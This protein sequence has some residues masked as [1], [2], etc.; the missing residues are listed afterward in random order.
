MRSGRL[1]AML[2]LMWGIACADPTGPGTDGVL[3]FR[4]RVD[5]SLWTPDNGAN[6]DAYLTPDG[7][8]LA[9][10]IRR[11]TLFRAIDGMAVIVRHVQGPGRYP[12]T[13][14][15]DRDHGLYGAFD[16]VNLTDTTFLSAPNSGEVEITQIDTAARRIAGRFSF[17]AQQVDETRRVR[18]SAGVFR[19]VYQTTLP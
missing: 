7:Y 11:D 18:I 17:E 13:S 12:L 8:F 16:P 15:F 5:E 2:V 14:D 9:R 6:T 3:F 19:V 4:A 10:A 1:S